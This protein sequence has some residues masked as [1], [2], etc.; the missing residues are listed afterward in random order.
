MPPDDN[1]LIQLDQEVHQIITT[2][3]VK[4][5]A[6]ILIFVVCHNILQ[7]C[8]NVCPPLINALTIVIF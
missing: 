6:N 7:L 3:T 4:I 1:Q 2:K 8:A 5:P